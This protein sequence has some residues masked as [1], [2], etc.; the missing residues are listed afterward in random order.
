VFTRIAAGASHTCALGTAGTVSCWGSNAF[1]QIGSAS[2]GGSFGRT[3]VQ[4]SVPFKAI[5]VG[6]NHTCAIGTDGETYCWGS[7][8]YGALGNELQAAF[9]SAPQKVATPR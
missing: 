5:A 4:S 8:S 6:S 9:R 2:I 7:N 3:T 1:G